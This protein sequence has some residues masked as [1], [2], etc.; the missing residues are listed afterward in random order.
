MEFPSLAE[1]TASFKTHQGIP[2]TFRIRQFHVTLEKF[3]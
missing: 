1:N 3:H 2:D